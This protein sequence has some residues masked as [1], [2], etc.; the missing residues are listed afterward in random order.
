MTLPAVAAQ[1]GQP[2]PAGVL[3]F[4]VAEAMSRFVFDQTKVHEDGMPAHGSS[5]I[6]T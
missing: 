2:S 6:T 5:F 3:K 4:D 1:P